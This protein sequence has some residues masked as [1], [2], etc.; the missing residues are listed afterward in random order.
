MQIS[1]EFIVTDHEIGNIY[2]AKATL[3]SHGY[4]FV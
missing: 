2:H 1:G 3:W 4:A